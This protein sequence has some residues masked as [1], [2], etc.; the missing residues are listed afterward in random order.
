MGSEMCI[1]DRYNDLVTLIDESGYQQYR[2]GIDGMD[3]V[4]ASN[5]ELKEF[6]NHIKEKIDP[7]Q[8]LSPGNY[9]IHAENN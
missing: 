6:L 7:K 5:P 1:R 4:L 2:T 3:A 9:R 8:T